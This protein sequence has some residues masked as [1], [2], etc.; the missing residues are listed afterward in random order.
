MAE[1][2]SPTK[3]VQRFISAAADKIWMLD[4][5]LFAVNA[6]VITIITMAEAMSPTKDTAATDKMWILEI[7]LY[8]QCRCHSHYRAPGWRLQRMWFLVS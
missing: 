2:M 1:A 3:D 8:R 7:G 4:M 5:G 6:G